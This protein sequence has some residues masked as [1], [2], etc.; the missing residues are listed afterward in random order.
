MKLDRSDD[1]YT[2]IPNVYSRVCMSTWTDIP[3][4]FCGNGHMGHKRKTSDYDI[5]AAE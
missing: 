4:V 5:V 3:H 2:N 1:Q